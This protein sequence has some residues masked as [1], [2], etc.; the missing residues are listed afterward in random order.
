[1]ANLI[2]E[3][4]PDIFFM[5]TKTNFGTNKKADHVSSLG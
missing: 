5:K 2:D 4:R 3:Q 1:M